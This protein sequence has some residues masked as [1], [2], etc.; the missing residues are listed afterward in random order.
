MGRVFGAG[1]VVAAAKNLG[2]KIAIVRVA[3]GSY[4]YFGLDTPICNEVA[5]LNKLRIFVQSYFVYRPGSEQLRYS[6]T[7]EKLGPYNV[8]AI[9]LS[10]DGGLS[11]NEV[12][13]QVKLYAEML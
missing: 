9:R 8:V 12:W 11:A 3:N 13:P 7:I 2:M 5:S 1:E 6:V 4:F 10:Q